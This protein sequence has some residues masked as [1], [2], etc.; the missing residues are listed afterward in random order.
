VTEPAA[1]AAYAQLFFDVN[2]R[3]GNAGYILHCGVGL[4]RAPAEA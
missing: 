2:G 4:H 3:L 1:V